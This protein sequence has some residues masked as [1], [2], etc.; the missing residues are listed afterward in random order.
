MMRV[1]IYTSSQVHYF[2]G[3]TRFSTEPLLS[4]S[5]SEWVAVKGEGSTGYFRVGDIRTIIITV[6]E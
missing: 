5:T 1:T 6:E 3:V 2:R 4:F